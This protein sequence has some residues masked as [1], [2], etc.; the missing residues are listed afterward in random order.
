M[1]NVLIGIIGVI[2]F[3]GLAMAGALFLG[4][5]F[6]SSSND[7]KGAAL[8]QQL[9]QA[10]SAA[11]MYAADSGVAVPSGELSASP[12]LGDYLKHAPINPSSG[13]G[14]AFLYDAAGQ[15]SGAAASAYIGMVLKNGTND[16]QICEAVQRSAGQIRSSEPFD[17]TVRTTGDIPGLQKVTGCVALGPA[18]FLVFS[19]I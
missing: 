18:R 13:G 12:L 5:R 1:S 14:P 19:T 10:S 6:R 3:I 17:P 4:D 16:R 8:V 11:S 15:W 2:L 7:S 9:Q